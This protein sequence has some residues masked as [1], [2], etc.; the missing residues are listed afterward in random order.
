MNDSEKNL[1]MSPDDANNA[2]SKSENNAEMLNAD[3]GKIIPVTDNGIG[4]E[5]E[6]D[7]M[8]I[9][10]GEDTD[11][12]G[13]PSTEPS[14]N[15]DISKLSKKGRGAK[16]KKRSG[17]RR[18]IWVLVT[19]VIAILI[20]IA[21][22][23]AANDVLGLVGSTAADI[24]IK[25][26]MN[27]KQIADVLK[28]NDIIDYPL[29][30]RAYVKLKHQDGTLK[31]GCFTL[32]E[33]MGYDGLIEQMQKSNERQTV[34][35]TIPDNAN[36][37]TIGALLEENSVCTADQFK[38]AMRSGSYNYDFV[39]AIPTDK[40][41]YRLEG[42]LYPDTYNFFTGDTSSYGADNAKH[43]IDKMLANFK[44][45]LE[46]K[47][48]DYK[49]KIAKLKNYGVTDLNS[50]LS[51]A[52]V[53]QLEC[54]GYTSEMPKVAAVF[55]NRLSWN[56]PHYL[57][58]T[59]TTRYKDKRYDTNTGTGKEGLPPGAQSCVTIDAIVAALNPDSGSIG[60]YYY[61]VTDSNGKFYYNKTLTQ[62]QNTIASLKSKGLWA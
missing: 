48:P 53:I 49:S 38:D 14:G 5:P 36:V 31:Y 21:A 37:D 1:D 6:T 12:D 52:S 51:M 7:N 30:F 44:S 4:G 13:L 43:A 19:V 2:E 18:L 40:V 28:E 54:T 57:G 8:P 42:Y 32:K 34:K 10:N 24:Q 47:C 23:L 55:Y 61:F 15:I 16:K 60:N 17:L 27:T 22:M 39:K 25:Q 50:L 59:P 11:D 33:T 20:S 29:L 26:G 3:A 56:E 58:S 62:H 45:K 46:E 41:Y 9:G 35:V